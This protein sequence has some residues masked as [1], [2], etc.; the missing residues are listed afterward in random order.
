MRIAAVGAAAF[1]LLALAV[2]LGLTRAADGAILAAAQSVRV[3]AFDLASTLLSVAGDGPVVAALLGALA[4]IA[5]RRRGASAFIPLAVLVVVTALEAAFKTVVDHPGPPPELSRGVPLPDWLRFLSPQFA[6]AFPSGHALRATYLFGLA[7]GGQRA[8]VVAAAV[9]AV[10]IW[11]S[12]LYAGEH[13][14]SDVAGGI[15][16]GVA[17]AALARLGRERARRR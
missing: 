14:P 13:W 10:L 6:N 12:R 8:V 2:A 1:A 9:F 5:F 7:V 3:P 15:A 16:L 17:A 4:L 11:I